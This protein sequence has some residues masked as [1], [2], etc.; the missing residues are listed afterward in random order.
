M[1]KADWLEKYYPIKAR[2]LSDASDV[3]AINHC[4]KKWEGLCDIE[5]YGLTLNKDIQDLSE[6]SGETVLLINGSSCALCSKYYDYNNGVCGE[7][8]LA[9]SLGRSCDEDE[10]TYKSVYGQARS[11]PQVMISALKKALEMVESEARQQ[12]LFEE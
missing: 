2:K 9:R 1:N 10:F 12:S 11:N 3:D 7:C 6:L 5:Q 4:I 8:P